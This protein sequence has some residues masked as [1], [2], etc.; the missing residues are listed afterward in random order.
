MGV[1]EVVQEG[2]SLWGWSE[3]SL[4]TAAVVASGA[5]YPLGSGSPRAGASASARSGAASFPSQACWG[6]EPNGC[7]NFQLSLPFCL[8]GP[9]WRG[10]VG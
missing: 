6:E 9:L 7:S 1:K 8:L 5:R 4:G 2:A 10:T 3:G